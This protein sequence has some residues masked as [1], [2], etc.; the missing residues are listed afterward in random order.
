LRRGAIVPLPAAHLRPH[1]ALL[2]YAA[3]HHP[4]SPPPPSRPAAACTLRRKFAGARGEAPDCRPGRSED[5][6]KPEGG[7]G[8]HEGS[9]AERESSRA[10]HRACRFATIPVVSSCP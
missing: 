7:S 9:A 6:G 5:R 8:C 3:H 1:R 4:P 10:D 2:G